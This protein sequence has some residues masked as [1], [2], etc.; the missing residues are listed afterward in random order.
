MLL[1]RKEETVPD[2]SATELDIACSVYSVGSV[3]PVQE[4][5]AGELAAQRGAFAALCRDAGRG[6]S[7]CGAGAADAGLCARADDIVDDLT[8]VLDVHDAL[9][10][11][12][13]EQLELCTA[14][15]R[16]AGAASARGQR[17]FEARQRALVRDVRAGRTEVLCELA[18]ATLAQW[19][20]HEGL[21]ATAVASAEEARDGTPVIAPA[22]A[23]L[24]VQWR[25]ELA[26]AHYRVFRALHGSTSLV[27]ADVRRLAIDCFVDAYLTPRGAAALGTFPPPTLA[28]FVDVFRAEGADLSPALVVLHYALLD[29]G[30]AALA[31]R[32]RAAFPL[33]P[34]MVQWTLAMWNVDRGAVALGVAALRRAGV[35]YDRVVLPLVRG[36][37]VRDPAAE[38]YQTLAVM[39]STPAATPRTAADALVRMLVLVRAGMLDTAF[40]YY[41]DAFC[42]PDSPLAP[43]LRAAP[44]GLPDRV[45]EAFF[46]T[47]LERGFTRVLVLLPFS[48]GETRALERLFVAHNM[49]TAAAA[50]QIAQG[51]P[52]RVQ[53][54]AR[55]HPTNPVL[56]TVA[57]NM[58]TG[59]DAAAP[60]ANT[61]AFSASL[62]AVSPTDAA[63]VAEKDAPSVNEAAEEM[64]DDKKVE[65]DEEKEDE[66]EIAVAPGN[67]TMLLAMKSPQR[68]PNR[69]TLPARSVPRDS[70]RPH[71]AEQDAVQ[72]AMV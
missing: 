33:A 14:A 3:R 24:Y 38:L 2:V 15:V 27:D 72:S 49:A 4:W 8:G 70:T 18:A 66:D 59:C 42:A 23:G 12:V 37:F 31:A 45:L 65:E 29:I 9:V 7:T 64:K 13:A 58:R 21:F 44:P 32:F 50:L 20:L 56:A 17:D 68:T 26:D 55:A 41:R 52:E 63:A 16:A 39:C 54:L 51:H 60:P 22:A 28:T 11:R 43:E 57:S 10:R 30:D 47:A 36:A 69:I 71:G 46:A 61:L 53:Q 62:A 1:K 25:A 48:D 5:L 67:T 19:L 6:G 35:L 40:A 34:R